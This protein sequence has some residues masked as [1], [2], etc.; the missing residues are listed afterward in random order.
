[1]CIVCSISCHASIAVPA[2]PLESLSASIAVLSIAS[3]S[4]RPATAACFRFLKKALRGSRADG[5]GHKGAGEQSLL[6]IGS[7]ALDHTRVHSRRKTRSRKRHTPALSINSTLNT[8]V[9]LHLLATCAQC[10]LPMLRTNWERCR[11]AVDHDSL[12]QSPGPP[13][14]NSTPAPPL[15]RHHG[16]RHFFEKKKGDRKTHNKGRHIIQFCMRTLHVVTFVKAI[17]LYVCVCMRS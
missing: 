5:A 15:H 1:M 14:Q 6:R 8:H 10:S 12:L 7:T 3:P 4:G 13:R 17:S 16:D 11:K 2:R 9:C